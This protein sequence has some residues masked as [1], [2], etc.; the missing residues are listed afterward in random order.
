M[1]VRVGEIESASPRHEFA[2]Q[3]KVDVHGQV[4]IASHDYF[5]YSFPMF[6][7]ESCF[8]PAVRIPA[9][10]R[11]QTHALSCK[12][13]SRAHFDHSTKTV[14]QSRG[15]VSQNESRCEWRGRALNG[16]FGYPYVG[17]WLI[18]WQRSHECGKLKVEARLVWNWPP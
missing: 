2:L 10:I 15:A 4:A 8:S 3:L 7:S 14:K 11:A 5:V 18:R 12:G 6:Q 1:G 16:T 13:H 9:D 17:T